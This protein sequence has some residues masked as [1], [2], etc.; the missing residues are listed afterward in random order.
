L[1]GIGPAGEL[2][3]HGITVMHDLPGVGANLQDH[4]DYVM[5]HTTRSGPE[6][7]GVSGAGSTMIR[8]AVMQWR[9]DRTGRLT[10][11]IAEAGAFLKSSPDLETPD[12]Q[13]TFAPGI[14]INHGKTMRLGHGMSI[15]VALA[16]AAFARGSQ[17]GLGRPR[18]RTPDRSAIPD[19][20]R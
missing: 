9:K 11:P 2:N 20:R 13:L 5:V 4:V 6:T 1:S 14:V 3:A 18:G 16:E 19:P 17:A 12:L 10:S 8:K 7:I 15:H